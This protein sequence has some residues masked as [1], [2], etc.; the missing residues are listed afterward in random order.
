MMQIGVR[1]Q[2][3]DAWTMLE[4][5]GVT[6]ELTLSASD[7]SD[8]TARKASHS[9]NIRLPFT[10]TN[11]RFFGH[12]SEVDIDNPTSYDTFDITKKTEGQVLDNGIPVM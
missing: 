2:S 7:I 3:T 8:I 11:D 10:P 4:T 6:M 1:N 5:E 9:L 12:V